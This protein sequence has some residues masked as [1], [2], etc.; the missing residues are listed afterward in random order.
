MTI[1]D[2]EWIIINFFTIFTTKNNF[3]QKKN[4]FLGIFYWKVS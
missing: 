2:L 3:L 4:S 1:F